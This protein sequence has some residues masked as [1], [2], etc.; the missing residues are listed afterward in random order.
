MDYG[1]LG[2]RMTLNEGGVLHQEQ[3]AVAE[4]TSAFSLP[5]GQP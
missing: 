5:Q 4:L 2:T 1:T 3:E